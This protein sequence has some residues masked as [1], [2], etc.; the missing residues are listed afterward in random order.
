[1]CDIEVCG[2]GVNMTERKAGSV[3]AGARLILEPFCIGAMTIVSIDILNSAVDIVQHSK[4][5][6]CGDQVYE[7]R[8]S[9]HLSQ[10]PH[11]FF[12]NKPMSHLDVQDA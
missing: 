6:F 1:M 11:I 7:S 2:A 8:M 12:S 10:R 3:P 4:T 9:T 5:V